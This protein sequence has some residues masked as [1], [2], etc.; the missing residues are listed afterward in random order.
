MDDKTIEEYKA[1]IERHEQEKREF[2]RTHIPGYDD[3][4]DRR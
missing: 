2:F 1:M 4:P 3:E